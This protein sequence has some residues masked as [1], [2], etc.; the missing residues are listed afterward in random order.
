MPVKIDKPARF[1]EL[2]QLDKFEGE[3]VSGETKEIF[4]R[5]C[6]G[7]CYLADVEAETSGGLLKGH[8][9]IF[10]DNSIKKFRLEWYDNFAI[11]ISGEGNYTDESTFIMIAKYSRNGSAHIERHTEKLIS[12]IKKIHM[13]EN[14]TNGEFE[15]IS[16]TTFDRK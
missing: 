15:K 12:G 2:D 5:A 7:F 9:I 16:E 11:H 6:D 1:P 13:I 4:K 10:F 3:W 8:G 14:F